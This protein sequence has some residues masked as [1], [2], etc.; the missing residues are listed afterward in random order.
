MKGSRPIDYWLLWAAVLALL[1][2][3]VWLWLTLTATRRQAADGAA[4]AASLIAGVRQT[5]ISYPVR[6]ERTVPISLSIPFRE[7]ITVP[8]K[9]TL[10]VDTL[11]N[12]PLQTPFGTLPIRVPIQANIPIDF[13]TD[14]PINAVVPVSST[15]PVELEIV[16]NIP[17]ADT[18]LG[19][20]L[21]EAE[22]YLRDLA[23]QLGGETAPAQETP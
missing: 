15:V 16:I 22:T 1:G 10:P 2:S 12:V 9:T 18:P 11:V 23:A 13:E 20:A 5:T 21:A 4:Q 8:I 6:V 7:T 17:I 19:Q 3:N 14:V